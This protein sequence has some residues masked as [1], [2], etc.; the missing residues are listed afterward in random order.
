M[1][2]FDAQLKAIVEGE[3]RPKDPGELLQF[4]RRAYDLTR[5]VTAARLWREALELDPRF[6]EDRQ[7]WH[8]YE[9]A[10]AAVLAGCGQGK[11]EA[12]PSDAQKTKLRQQALDGLTGEIGAWAKFLETASDQQRRVVVERLQHWQRDPDLAGI[13]EDA[14]LAK[15]PEAERVAFR[16]LWGDLDALLK[17]ASGP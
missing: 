2:A 16:K 3:K 10:C 12:P 9:A 13:R 4:A 11:H 7:A 14:E 1:A 6:G 5:Y 17:K 8:R 15:L